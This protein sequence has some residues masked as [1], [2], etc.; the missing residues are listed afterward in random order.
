MGIHPVG[1]LMA[2]PRLL[3]SVSKYENLLGKAIKEE[4]DRAADEALAEREAAAGRAL[5]AE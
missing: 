2:V 4:R 5:L 3:E 1:K